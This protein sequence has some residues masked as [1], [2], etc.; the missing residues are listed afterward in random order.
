MIEMTKHLIGNEP[1]SLI[2][3][4][5]PSDNNLVRIGERGGI[6]DELIYISGLWD[7]VANCEFELMKSIKSVI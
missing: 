1:D 7:T 5:Q 6:S 4:F 3:Y 2:L